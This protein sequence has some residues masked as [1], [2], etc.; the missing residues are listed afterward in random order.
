MYSIASSKKMERFRAEDGT[1][2]TN[3]VKYSIILF[4]A[5][6]LIITSLYFN[7]M[8]EIIDG[9]IKINMAPSI[10]V[11][12]YIA[13]G[14]IGATLVNA[15]LLMVI[16]LIVAKINNA[17]MNGPIVA[18]VV[19]VGAFAFLGKNLYNIWAIFL[20][21]YLYATIKKEKFSKFI[22]VA[23]FG[24][25]LGPMVS[26]ITFGIEL[27]LMYGIVLGN[28]FGIVAGFIMPSLASH[29]SK[30][31]HGFNLYNMGFT[32]GIAGTLLM[33]LLRA[34]GKNHET[35][36][37]LSEGNNLIFTIYF[38][39]MFLSM[40]GI[41]YL[42]NNKSFSG[43]RILMG[44]S[45]RAGTDF[46]ALDGFGISMVNMG[47]IGFLSMAYVLLVR[48]QLNGPNIGGVLTIVAFGAM[49]KH[50]K[51]IIPIFL[52]VF[53]ASATQ[54]WN[55]N[56]TGPMLAALFGTTLAPIAGEYGWKVGIIAG[57]MHMI[58]VMNTGYLHGGMNLYNNGFAGGIVAA[59]LVTFVNAL[60]KEEI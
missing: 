58:M 45:G 29:F 15:G 55:V 40:I 13:V 20:G 49:G 37:I 24:T 46:I 28:L 48:G 39:I 54:I 36:A 25:A 27:P 26:Q 14:N 4:Y 16:S 23:L 56:A 47:L 9:L 38:S 10:L 53:I 43:Y 1:Y 42:L 7:S 11:T 21:V 52:G 33:S 50:P 35:V 19:T 57:F 31:H 5:I 30:F 18:A 59:I 32:A 3:T 51:N 34:Y 41:G 2:T 44:R 60:K 22:T 6:F 12:D 8:E 17:D